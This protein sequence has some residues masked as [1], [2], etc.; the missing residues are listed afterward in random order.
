MMLSISSFREL[1]ENSDVNVLFSTTTY[2]FDDNGVPKKCDEG[3]DFSDFRYLV[4]ADARGKK[5]GV[6]TDQNYQKYFGKTFYLYLP[7]TILDYCRFVSI[8]TRIFGWYIPN[9][10]FHPSIPL[11]IDP[12]NEGLSINWHRGLCNIQCSSTTRNI[13]SSTTQSSSSLPIVTYYIKQGTLPDNLLNPTMKNKVV[14]LVHSIGCGA[15]KEILSFTIN[16]HVLDEMIQKSPVFDVYHCPGNLNLEWDRIEAMGATPLHAPL[17]RRGK[18]KNK[19][20]LDHRFFLIDHNA[21]SKRDDALLKLAGIRPLVHRGHR[22]Y[23]FAVPLGG[24]YCSM[25]RWFNTLLN[26]LTDRIGTGDMWLTDPV[27]YTGV[28]SAI[29]VMSNGNIERRYRPY[30]KGFKGMGTLKYI[31]NEKIRNGLE[32]WLKQLKH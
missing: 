25:T 14:K 27:F 10:V 7:Y 5:I 15:K 3:I 4:V 11:S 13:Y 20:Y 21:V 29:P 1:C 23:A 30:F 8:I 6:C 17:R 31:K 22:A 32:N 12:G 24:E 9:T 16:N 19:D 26:Y 2:C 18:L 28:T